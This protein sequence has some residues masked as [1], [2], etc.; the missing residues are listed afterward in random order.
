MKNLVMFGLIAFAC[1]GVFADMEP[2]VWTPEAIAKSVEATTRPKDEAS[3]MAYAKAAEPGRETEWKEAKGHEG[4]WCVC[5][6]NNGWDEMAKHC[7]LASEAA[8]D[9]K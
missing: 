7:K 6:A 4:K 2:K 1:N 9:L 8:G 5:K 3:C